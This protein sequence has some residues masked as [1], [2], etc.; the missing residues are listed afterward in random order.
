MKF[1]DYYKTLGIAR[2]ADP[3]E[4]K[5]AYRRLAR[6]LHPDVSK[7]PNATE[8]FQEV[9]EAYEVLK[10]PEKREA[11]D[12]FGAD[13][14]AGQEFRPPPGWE[15]E[16]NFPG[17]GYTEARDFSDF[18]DALFGGARHGPSAHDHVHVRVKR[19]DIHT[20]IEIPL[21][22][23]FSGA[24]REIAVQFPGLDEQG[25]LAPKM[26][27]LRVRIP[28]GVRQGQRIR[29]RGQGG[30]GLGGATA[31]DL[32]L[33]VAFASHPY[34]HALGRN[35]Y[36]DL[37]VAPWEAALGEVVTVPTLAGEVDLKIPPGSRT[38]TKLRL[39][40][41]GLPGTPAGDQFVAGSRSRLRKRTRMRPGPSTSG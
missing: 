23:S 1:R 41:R 7:E 22:D 6:K 12:R 15:P 32:Y 13:W 2:D 38:G 31:G 17:G 36:L 5:R 35:I 27:R 28:K 4:V 33:E 25:R 19:E 24:T 39:K 29:L 16:V 10:D 20:R 9:Q 37:P 34:F 18:F 14:K 21:E 11:Y 40:G 3:E 30:P 26:R 8:R